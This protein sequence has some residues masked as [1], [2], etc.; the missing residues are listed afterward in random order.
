MG[1]RE[2]AAELEEEQIAVT[3]AEDSPLAIAW[4]SPY[5]SMPGGMELVGIAREKLTGATGQVDTAG[6]N[7]RERNTADS[8]ER[9]S[10]I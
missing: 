3:S 2:E 10:T 5:C 7:N 9:A 8:V 6:Y 4:R 1:D